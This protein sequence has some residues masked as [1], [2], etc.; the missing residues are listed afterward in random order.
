MKKIVKNISLIQT[1]ERSRR[2]RGREV[3]CREREIIGVPV[4]IFAKVSERGRIKV[5]RVQIAGYGDFFAYV[6]NV[7]SGKFFMF[8]SF[9]GMMGGEFWALSGRA[10]RSFNNW[11]EGVT[12]NSIADKVSQL[13][14]KF[15]GDLQEVSTHRQ[16]TIM[17][18]ENANLGTHFVSLQKTHHLQNCKLRTQ[19]VSLQKT[20]ERYDISV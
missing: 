5:A 17:Q 3:N 12:I 8:S 11:K 10:M 20:S 14:V 1:F 7:F 6:G 16:K 18:S 4:L 9:L 15:C 19:I 13:P 2:L